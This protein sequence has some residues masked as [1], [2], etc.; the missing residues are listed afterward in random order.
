[1]QDSAK[2]PIA[3]RVKKTA[4]AVGNICEIMAI[5]VLFIMM[6]VT[7]CDVVARYFFNS[8]ISGAFELTEIFLG[9]LVF[10]S[11][12]VAALTDSH[13]KVDVFE[14]VGGKLTKRFIQAF[15]SVIGIIVFVVLTVQLW[16]HA[17]KLERY[18]QVTNSLEIPLYLV[19]MLAAFCCFI[20]VILMAVQSLS[21]KKE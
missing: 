8:P 18:E 11:L 4:F 10:L 20:C 16:K 6:F 19:G 9:V 15:A 13:I 12:P 7:G 21:S 14:N 5:I 17:V 3:N 2:N 1:M